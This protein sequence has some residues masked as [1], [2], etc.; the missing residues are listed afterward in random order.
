[1]TD[2]DSGREAFD[3]AIALSRTLLEKG[4]LT[5]EEWLGIGKWAEKMSADSLA[6]FEAYKASTPQERKMFYRLG[7]RA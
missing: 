3:Y 7:D 1:M 4:L 5:E 6:E 2:C